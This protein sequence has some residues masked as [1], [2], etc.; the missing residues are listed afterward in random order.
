MIAS[1]LK[2]LQKLYIQGSV[3]LN[4]LVD[5]RDEIQEFLSCQTGGTQFPRSNISNCRLGSCLFGVV[6]HGGIVTLVLAL[7]SLSFQCSA[8]FAKF[9]KIAKIATRLGDLSFPAF[10]SFAIFCN[11]CKNHQNRKNRSTFGG[12]MPSLAFRC[13]AIFA[14]FRNFCKNRTTLRL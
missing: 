3:I 4:S 6:T 8:I 5:T 13:S 12:L 11:F 14:I 9:V 1:V 7:F 2:R 10:E